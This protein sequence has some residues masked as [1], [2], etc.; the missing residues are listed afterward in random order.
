MTRKISSMTITDVRIAS[1]LLT[2]I[3]IQRQ[4]CTFNFKCRVQGFC[5]GKATF[6]SSIVFESE[7]FM[8]I[9]KKKE[10]TQRAQ[11]DVKVFSPYICQKK[12]GSQKQTLSKVVLSPKSSTGIVFEKSSRKNEV[13]VVLGANGRSQKKITHVANSKTFKI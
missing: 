10:K 12:A 3:Y 1:F 6:K 13:P 9:R 5:F 7:Y 2:L 11:K 4:R 8:I